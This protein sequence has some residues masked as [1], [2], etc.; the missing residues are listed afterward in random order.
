MNENNGL[1]NTTQTIKATQTIDIEVARRCYGMVTVPVEL[2][3]FVVIVVLLP[4]D[5]TTA[6]KLV[7]STQVYKM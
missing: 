7:R 6:C 2:V 1:Q 5:R 4:N 3:Q